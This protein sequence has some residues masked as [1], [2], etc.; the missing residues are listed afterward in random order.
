MAAGRTKAVKPDGL[1]ELPGG[2]IEAIRNKRVV[3][4]LGAGAS[5]ESRGPNGEKPPS[6]NDLRDRL[7]TEFLGTKIENADL[8]SVADMAIEMAGQS[9]VFEKIRFMLSPLL[10]TPA[11]KLLATFRWRALVTTNYDELIEK[12]YRATRSP[13]QNIVP[14]VKNTEPVEELLQSTERPVVLLK[15]HGCITHAHDEQVPLVL[16]HEHY[17]LHDRHRGNLYARMNQWTHEST[18]VFCGY[19]IGDAHIRNILHKLDADG[20]KRPTYYVV[21]PSMDEIQAAYWAKKKVTLIQSTFGKFMSAIDSALPEMWRTLEAGQGL[22]ELSVRSHFRTNRDPSPGLSSALD[23][24]FR[25]V[26]ASMAAEPQVPR[27]FYEGFDTGWGAILQDLDIRRRVMNDLLSK[28]VIEEESDHETRLILLR[29]PAGSG[30]SVL[31]KRSAMMAA[32]DLEQLVLWL[33]PDGALRAESVLELADLTGKR[34]YVFVDRA[35]VHVARIEAL[36][37]SAKQKNVA[38]TIVAAERDSE[39]NTFAPRVTERW[40][41]QDFRLANLAPSEIEDLVTI[42]GR[43]DSLGLLSTHTREQQIEAFKK[44]ADR[45]L[46]VALHEATRGK[47]F[48]EIVHD[49][50]LGIGSDRA[51]RL[52]LDICTLNQFAVPVRA[53]TISRVAGIRFDDYRQNLFEPLENVVLTDENRYTGDIEY[54]ARHPRVA[55]FVFQGACP[56]DEAK[57]AQLTR[58]IEHLDAGFQPDRIA[59][60]GIAKGRSLS[61][62]LASAA[63]GREIYSALAKVLPE[64]AFLFQQWAIFEYTVQGGSLEEAERL[65]LQAKDIDP[66]SKS[67]AHTLAEVARRR[68]ASEKSPLVKE[69]F[70]RLARQRLNDAGTATDMLVMSSK[71]KLLVDDV[72]DVVEALGDAYDEEDAAKLSDLVRETEQEIQ[73]AQQLYH[74]FADLDE[75]EWRLN[76]IMDQHGKA[77]RALERAWRKNPR[78]TSVAIR[79]AKDYLSHDEIEKARLILAE[80]LQRFPEDRDIHLAMARFLLRTESELTERVGEH[81]ERSYRKG[82]RNYDARHLH[83]QFL[84][85]RG[86]VK[87]AQDL[88]EDVQDR[89]PAEFRSSSRKPSSDLARHIA[90]SVG[91]VVAK[92]STFCFIRSPSYGKDIYANEADSDVAVWENVQT[93]SQVDFKVMFKRGGPVAHDLQP[94]SG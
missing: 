35:A 93:G 88:F 24:D 80:A 72:K 94:V 4:F 50:Y 92:D 45:Q 54:R 41:P 44:R 77:I 7:S 68:A 5:M 58:M 39:W 20:I 75:T 3:L 60:E 69:Q 23:R 89:A 91:R 62:V 78:G 55:E 52:Y 73:K 28:A 21:T 26:H 2:L 59:I 15:L 85:C 70:R 65:A 51:R 31:L 6:A 34:I 9:V 53:G 29:G 18:F 38:V 66:K 12:G 17:A 46:L 47:A 10:P 82:D 79:L 49:E 14:V 1:P 37:K 84:F 16:S 22:K 57:S 48:E 27:R 33:Q 25:H 19:G 36:L 43:H 71:C 56:S 11:H 81:L 32:E 42:L 64:A 87:K 86:D 40:K 63:S 76:V 83:A 90:R 30:K 8:M 74:E 13:L 67:V 61:G